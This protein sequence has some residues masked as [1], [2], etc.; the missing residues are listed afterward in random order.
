MIGDWSQPNDVRL[1]SLFECV[2]IFSRSILFRRPI[3]K[4]NT[5]T[6]NIKIW[7][8]T[9]LKFSLYNFNFTAQPRQSVI[10]NVIS[11]YWYANDMHTGS[12]T[13]VMYYE[14]FQTDIVRIM[15]ISGIL[16]WCDHDHVNECHINFTNIAIDNLRHGASSWLL[17]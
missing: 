2:Y 11:C 6:D 16:Y 12:G 9:I 15:M 5:F 7:P 14:H 13:I 8:T 1:A 10:T 3:Y 4:M 17:R